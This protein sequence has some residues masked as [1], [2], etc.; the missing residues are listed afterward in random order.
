MDTCDI[1]IKRILTLYLAM[2][3]TSLLEQCQELCDRSL[4]V[5]L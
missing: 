1:V 3:L 5:S 2:K 4:I